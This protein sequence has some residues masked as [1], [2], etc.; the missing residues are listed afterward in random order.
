MEYVIIVEGR[1]I[2]LQ[3]ASGDAETVVRSGGQNL[4]LGCL[5]SRS[6][7]PTRN[8][9]RRKEK[10]LQTP[11]NML[12]MARGSSPVT[13]HQMSLGEQ[14]F[15]HMPFSQHEPEQVIEAHIKEQMAMAAWR[16][17]VQGSRR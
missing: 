10:Q 8:Q 11:T 12:Y 9:A 4:G 6:I 15:P 3:D 14:P 17:R 13:I 2:L 1:G 7:S 16:L 5:I